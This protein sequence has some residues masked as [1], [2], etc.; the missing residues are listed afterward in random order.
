[1]QNGQRFTRSQQRV[2]FLK[3]VRLE[4]VIFTMARI[5]LILTLLQIYLN[6]ILS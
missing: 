1:M 3:I 2:K 6:I 4:I 5:L